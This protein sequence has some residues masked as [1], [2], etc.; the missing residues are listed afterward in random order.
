MAEAAVDRDLAAETGGSGTS[1]L[2]HGFTMPCCN[3]VEYA[4]PG[5]YDRE[6]TI[7]TLGHSRF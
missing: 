6:M 1:A 3:A 7:L 4:Y 2:Q 5:T